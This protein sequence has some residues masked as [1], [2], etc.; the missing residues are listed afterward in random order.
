MS[1]TIHYE[2]QH[3]ITA[4]D[5]MRKLSLSFVIPQSFES[6]T[7]NQ[8]ITNFK[9]TFS[10]EPQEKATATDARGNK[11]ILATWTRVPGKI[12]A[13]VSFD[14]AN[15]TGLKP[16]ETNSPFPLAPLPASMADY[17]KAT[18]QVQSDSPEIRKLCGAIDKR[19]QNSV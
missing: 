3:Q 15:L 9:M 1:S 8:Q 18:E 5:A 14:A 16:M 6:P 11:T 13:V 4:G 7:Y 19:R 2:L 17:L 12:D 10:P